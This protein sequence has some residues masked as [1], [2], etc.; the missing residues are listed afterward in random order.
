MEASSTATIDL[1][2]G[3]FDYTYEEP[4]ID[5][6]FD[7]AGF[8]SRLPDPFTTAEIRQWVENTIDRLSPQPGHRVLEI[9]CGVGLLLWQLVDRCQSYVGLDISVTAV[10]RLR[11]A[12]QLLGISHATVVCA[13]ATEAADHVRGEVDLIV[14]NSVSQFFPGTQHLRK[15]LD[16]ALSVL[17]PGGRV[18]V[19]DVRNADL[20]DALL[21]GVVDADAHFASRRQQLREVIATERE[22]LLSPV[23]FARYAEERGLA[24]RA[25][26][27]LGQAANELNKYRFDVVLSR[28]SAA[29]D[30]NFRPWEGPK[31]LASAVQSGRLTG[32]R[33]VPHPGATDAADEAYQILYG[34]PEAGATRP[35]PGVRPCELSGE[36]QVSLL[37]GA[38]GGAYDLVVGP[39]ADRV[40]MPVAPDG[41]AR[42]ATTPWTVGDTP[43]QRE[44]PLSA[45]A[46]PFDLRPAAVVEVT[47]TD[48][49]LPRPW[50][51]D[52]TDP[53]APGQ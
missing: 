8:R 32:F 28:E 34:G 23:W 40:R 52:A 25:M 18:F 44:S 33:S 35:H 50:G 45:L 21:L 9:G 30:I 49:T 38:D 43:A 13:E 1:W 31:A 10:N 27:K 15:V 29:E 14:V 37:G 4:P 6:G 11:A 3:V 19:G 47:D 24:V 22:L 39:G 26:P 53:F 20:L 36:F 17:A 48:G 46:R 12:L 42:L 7:T 16:V 2:A 41:R 5:V 51:L